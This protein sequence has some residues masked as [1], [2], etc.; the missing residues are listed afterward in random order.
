MPLVAEPV[1]H[2]ADGRH[3]ELVRMV[4]RLVGWKQQSGA[5]A[6]ADG[7]VDELG[8]GA[9]TETLNSGRE[10]L[11]VVRAELALVDKDGVR[12]VEEIL[13]TGFYPRL[14]TRLHGK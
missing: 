8:H 2:T 12:A 7:F 10:G 1:V 5:Q 4:E 6:L 14:E 9:V 3:D 11:G 13:Q